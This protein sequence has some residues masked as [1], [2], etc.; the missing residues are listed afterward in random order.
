MDYH[1][2]EIS[3]ITFG[4]YSAEE[5]KKMSVCKLHSSK[6]NGYGSVYDD[7][8]GTCDSSKLCE[9]CNE[10]VDVCPGHFG[11]IELHE[12]IIH[13]LYYKRV[14]AF[15]NCTCLKCHRLLILKD[16]VYLCGLNKYKG[17]SR[18]IKIQEKLKKVE[19][20]CHEDCGVDNP[21]CKFSTS[22]STFLKVYEGKDKSKTSIVI[23]TE[24]IKTIFDNMS[25]DDIELMGFDPDIVHPRTLVLSI[26]PVLPICARPYV[27]ADGN[28]CDDDL[29][30][31]YFEIIKINNHLASIEVGPGKKELSETKRQKFL[32]SLRFR[33]MTTFNNAQGKAKH[34]T[35]GRAI[36]GI[37]ER[38]SGKEG[39]LRSNLLGKRCNQTGRT[40]IGPDP[41]LKFGQIAIPKEMANTLTIPVVVTNFNID[42]LQDLVDRGQVDSVLK[43]DG[44][45]RINLKRYRRGTRLIDGDVIIRNSENIK[46]VTGREMI[47][48]GDVV[49]RNG[50]EMEKIIHSN[51]S[52]K[53]EIGWT[54]ERKLQDNDY[55]L[56]NRQP[57]LHKA[58]MMSVQILIKNNKTIRMN[59]AITKPFNADFDGDEMNIHVPQSLESQAELRLLS[60][61]Q[62]NIISAQSSKP[63][64]SIVQDSLLGAYR[65]TQGVKK[66]TRE[67]FFNIVNKLELTPSG[68]P[69]EKIL[70]RI[71]H[72]RSVLKSKGKKI[73]CFTGKGIISMFLPKDFIYE[74]KNNADPDEPIVKIWKGVLYE[75][76]LNKEN[77]GSSHSSLIHLINKEYGASAAAHFV[78]CVQFCTNEWNLIHIFTIGLGDCL[79]TNKQKEEEIQDVIKKC[80]IEAEGIKSTTTHAGF[81]EMRVNA[82]LSKAKDIGLRIAKESLNQDNN[83]LSTVNS[84]SKGDFF[85]IAQITGL[86]GQQNLKGQR[87]SKVLNHGQRTLPHYPFGDLA[88]EVEYESRGFVASSFIHGLNPREFYFHAMSGREGI[89]DT[90]MGT[91]TSGYMQR[92]IIKLTE[93]IKVQYDG[94]VRDIPGNIFQLSYGDYGL[95]PTTTVKVND[96]Q[97][98]CDIS[99]M[100]TRLNMNYEDSSKK[101]KSVKC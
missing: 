90:A 76:T 88:P 54:V 70:D 48:K 69:E 89:S 83:F 55:V 28:I 38:M 49:K 25:V 93:D 66:I 31:Q 72:I 86:L 98:P 5:I 87:V 41:T 36:K 3:S 78:D 20:C 34:T 13:P 84:G 62:W 29:T 61:V 23:T 16:Q 74:K 59:L 94:T 14:V 8:M 10:S 64:I 43:P 101:K 39:Q 51:R 26:I 99:R 75:G 42:I 57:T 40:V 9:T 6:K 96:D 47:I 12:P 68:F 30:N 58:S 65:M 97:Q 18:F 27:K 73:Q 24:E 71:Q 53:L 15:L 2:Q 37:K 82:T 67:Q 81:R 7:R 80:Y 22:D 21:K 95:D 19:M 60:A 17:E 63:N 50:I 32:A 33:V 100:V 91:A 1:T 11:H 4:I 45:T 35:N 56:L 92:R 52:Y 79:V 85:N 46:V 77:I 44:K